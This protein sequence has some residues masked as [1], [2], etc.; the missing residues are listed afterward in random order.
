MVRRQKKRRF[1]QAQTD[2][3]QIFLGTSD[4]VSDGELQKHNNMN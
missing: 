2:V 1:F 4:T 3:K